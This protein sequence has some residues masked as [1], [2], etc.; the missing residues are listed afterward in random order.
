MK[1][2]KIDKISTHIGENCLITGSIIIKG[3]IVIN[4]KVEGKIESDGIVIIGKT[5]IISSDI[6]AEECLITG[7]VN[8]NINVRKTLEL[9]KTAILKG[10]IVAQ[11]LKVHSGAVFN[12]NC[13]MEIKSDSNEQ[14]LLI[15]KDVEET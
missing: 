6:T 1:R 14:E 2:Y 11:I 9:D 4:G 5:G 15:A 12:G 3:G 13:L 7:A 8:G 10:N